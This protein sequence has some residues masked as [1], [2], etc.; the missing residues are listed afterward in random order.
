MYFVPRWNWPSGSGEDLLTW[1]MHF[2]Y[3]VI[4]S[5]FNGMCPFIRTNLNS[6]HRMMLWAK[7]GWNRPTRSREKDFKNFV[8]LFSL[9]RNISLWEWAWPLILTNLNPLHLRMLYPMSDW[10]WSNGSEEVKNVKSL[11][12]D[13]RRTTGVQNSSFELSAQL[14]FKRLNH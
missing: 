8:N 9:F 13:S 12:I 5:F 1:S 6:L 2:C 11:Q 14:R 3:F 7:F 4:I 10:N